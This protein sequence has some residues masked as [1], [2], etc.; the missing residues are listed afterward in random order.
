M[1][2]KFEY[3]NSDHFGHRCPFSHS[4]IFYPHIFEDA[5]TSAVIWSLAILQEH[6]EIAE[7]IRQEVA[8]SLAKNHTYK[9]S[10]VFEE[11]KFTWKV[12]LL[13]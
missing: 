13:C 7:K 12:I 5:T 11:L 9:I 8:K 10:D 6:P 2:Y 1:V 4:K 3:L